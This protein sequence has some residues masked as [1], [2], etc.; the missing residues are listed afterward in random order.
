MSG[1]E[2]NEKVVRRYF[3]GG[4]DPTRLTLEKVFPYGDV[5]VSSP[6]AEVG[7]RLQVIIEGN[8][9][10]LE[11]LEERLEFLFGSE[12]KRKNKYGRWTDVVPFEEG[13]GLKVLFRPINQRVASIIPLILIFRLDLVLRC[14]LK[15][16]EFSHMIGQMDNVVFLDQI[17]P[18]PKEIRNGSAEIPAL[19]STKVPENL[20]SKMN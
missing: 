13:P 17:I 6:V 8:E 9:S 19:I 11:F 4:A 18:L 3:L 12:R 7:K 5:I 2:H 14:D 15:L 16:A 1:N 10:A 20:L